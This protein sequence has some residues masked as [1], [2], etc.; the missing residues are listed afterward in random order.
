[1]DLEKKELFLTCILIFRKTEWIC[2]YNE[3]F[4]PF[5]LYSG[6]MDGKAG[7]GCDGGQTEIHR[8]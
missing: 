4:D 3:C 2:L 5:M 6:T 8:P 1:M 7:C